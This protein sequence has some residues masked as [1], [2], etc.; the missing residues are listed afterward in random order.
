MASYRRMWV[1]AAASGAEQCRVD[2]GA[3][4]VRRF[5]AGLCRRRLLVSA[6]GS[7]H[8]CAESDHGAGLV[9]P[10]RLRQQRTN[11]LNS[12]TYG[13]DV[14]SPQSRNLDVA[15][16]YFQ[17]AV[18]SGGYG[19]YLPSDNLP[20][21]WLTGSAEKMLVGYPVDGSQFGFTNIVSG[22][23]YQ[24]GPE[25]DALTLDPGRP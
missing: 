2:G 4:G 19:G 5:S 10:Q 16:L 25:A 20:N 22:T 12:G 6:G 21:Q 7:S 18:A 3:C 23:M 8:L 15:A 1:S 24:V 13:A 11:D 14:S 9:C 17:S